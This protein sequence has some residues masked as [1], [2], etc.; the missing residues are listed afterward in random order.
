LIELLVISEAGSS[1][2]AVRNLN[3]LIKLLRLNKNF[4]IGKCLEESN[5][6]LSEQSTKDALEILFIENIY[7]KE[8]T[9]EKFLHKNLWIFNEFSNYPLSKISMNF[10]VKDTKS[11]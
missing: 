7:N 11:S 5:L 10:K 3:L 4:K 8:N 9:Y 6:V 2:K 1:T